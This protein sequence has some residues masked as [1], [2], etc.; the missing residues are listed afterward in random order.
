[1]SRRWGLSLQFET[2]LRRGLLALFLRFPYGGIPAGIAGGVIK[3]EDSSLVPYLLHQVR[4]DLSVAYFLY[5]VVKREAWFPHLQA[6]MVVPV[7][8]IRGL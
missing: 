3:R 8:G 6:I 2:Q 7:D 5:H 4:Q 1:M